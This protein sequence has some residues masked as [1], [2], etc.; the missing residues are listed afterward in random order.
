[1][2][3]DGPTV[4]KSRGVDSQQ[5]SVLT[6]LLNSSR[7]RSQQVA[8]LEEAAEVAVGQIGDITVH[9]RRVAEQLEKGA[10]VTEAKPLHDIALILARVQGEEGSKF[11]VETCAKAKVAPLMVQV[12]KVHRAKGEA[13]TAKANSLALSALVNIACLDGHRQILEAGGLELFAGL[14]KTVDRKKEPGTALYA[15]AG[16]RNLSNHVGAA[17]RLRKLG[18]EKPLEKLLAVADDETTIAYASATLQH[19]HH[20]NS[21][22]KRMDKVHAINLINI[23]CCCCCRFSP[24]APTAICSHC[25]PPYNNTTPYG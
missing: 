11:A 8:A 19:I 22:A 9:A 3:A 13:W 4:A 10:A 20:I 7:S 5:M 21:R 1:M 24:R 6:H 25:P 23:C 15:L 18:V 14:L 12:T 2:G 17:E 16:L